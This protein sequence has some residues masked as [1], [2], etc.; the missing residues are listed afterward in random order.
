MS[1]ATAMQSIKRVV[2]GG[3]IADELVKGGAASTTS[4]PVT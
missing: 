3:E 1:V 2:F 4:V